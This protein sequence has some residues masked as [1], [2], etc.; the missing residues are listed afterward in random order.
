MAAPKKN[1]MAI[2]YSQKHLL[3]PKLFEE[4]EAVCLLFIGNEDGKNDQI[5]SMKDDIMT[6][7]KTHNFC[8]EVTYKPKQVGPHPCNRDGEGLSEAR[9]QSR[10][11]VMHHGGFSKQTMR[12]NSISMQDHPIHKYVEEFALKMICKSPRYARLQKNMILAGTLGAGHSMHGLAQVLDEVPCE[13][14]R[15]SHA[16]RMSKQ[17]CFADKGIRSACED[18]VTFDEIDYRVEIVFPMVPYIVSAAL[19]TVTQV[20]MGEN[21]HSMLMKITSH[22][23]TAWPAPDM[24]NIKKTVIKSQPPRPQDVADMADFVRKWG[25]LPSGS[26]IE[27]IS[28]LANLF[29]P[30]SHIVP[31]SF[32]KI[33]YD[34]PVSASAMPAEFISAL[35]FAHAKTEH[36]VSDS[37][38]RSYIKGDIVQLTKKEKI[39]RPWKQTR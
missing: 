27:E 12:A 16:G 9:A 3:P 18:G 26:F 32:F 34:L 35:V 2:D 29:C 7:T 37:V 20:A 14:P 21:W 25:G 1:I 13:L 4:L 19:N 15:I 10:V 39:H 5:V 23:K 24:N 17:L 33:L 38:C 6:S 28:E 11:Q 31:G 8:R 36:K 22:I 30:P